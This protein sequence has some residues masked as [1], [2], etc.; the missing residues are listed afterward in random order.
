MK[1]MQEPTSELHEIL[2]IDP[3]HIQAYEEL[4]MRL[5]TP[6][7]E[8]MSQEEHE[9]MEADYTAYMEAA[10]TAYMEEHRGHEIYSTHCDEPCCRYS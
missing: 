9:Y 2:K 1:I 7:D 8:Y 3:K 10:Y 4:C 5:Y 6:E